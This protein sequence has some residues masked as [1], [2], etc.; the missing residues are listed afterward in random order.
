MSSKKRLLWKL[1]PSYLA[2]VVLAIIAVAWFSSS[3]FE[4]HHEHETTATLQ[5][6][7]RLAATHIERT[8]ML[9]DGQDVNAFCEEA[10]KRTTT[11]FTVVLADG[12]VIGDS[13]ESPAGME[14]HADR[15]EIERALTHG[16]GAQSRYSRTLRTHMRYVA[17]PIM[18]DGVAIA[19]V[20][21]S[22]QLVTI[23][24]GIAQSLRHILGVSAAVALLAAAVTLA[25]AKRITRPL[26][27][28][29]AGA[30]RFANGDF[31]HHLPEPD[32]LELHEL[33]TGMNKMATQL[34]ERIEMI[35]QRRNELAAI[36]ASM[37]EGVLAVDKE[38]RLLIVNEGA[39]GILEQAVDQAHGKTV[40]EVIRNSALQ[41]LI[42]AALDSDDVVEGE[43][44][45]YGRDG[46]RVVRV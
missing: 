7:A 6:L 37:S 45:Y 28:M 15:P 33:A 20:R 31:S 12:T 32:A 23:R 1:Y 4:N 14:N 11:R 44:T 22:R 9:A 18:H 27:T 26:E 40:Q 13:E 24:E 36:L 42:A 5:Q 16:L 35:T 19:T 3:S 8:G 25:V 41:A 34:A 39:A 46:E 30:E 43:I 29:R 10:G 21:A 17:V 38:E 2:V